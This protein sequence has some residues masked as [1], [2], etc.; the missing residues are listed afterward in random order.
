MVAIDIEAG[1]EVQADVNYI[2]NPRLSLAE[3]K[4]EFCTEDES[5]STMQT[6]PGEVMAIRSARALST[7]L[8]QQGFL[9][10][11]HVTS[12]ADFN[13]IEGDP[14]TDQLY[15]EEMSALLQQVT[16]ASFAIML[17]TGKKRFGESAID[18]L[19]PLIN[20][21]P[22]RYAHADNTDISA[23]EMFEYITSAT[24]QQFP[25]GARWAMYNL[26]RAVSPPPQDFP[27]AVC[28]AT[29]VDPADEV[30][31]TAVTSTLS[32][33]DMRHD[34]TGYLHNPRHRWH[35]YPDMTKDEVIIFKAHDSQENVLRR[36]P[37]TAFTD[38]TCPPGTPTR[39][40]VESRGLAIFA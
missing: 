29:S 35:Y 33:G 14:A 11:D 17:G 4:L 23:S 18:K 16:G 5:L 15:N 24:G 8:D 3:P 28:D 31:V 40:S 10:V 37:H 21:K 7:S 38:P 19:A 39:A 30:P 13:L 36:V 22:A 1:L 12:V 25:K 6:L 9:L 27:L 34:T 32:T 2:R 20:A 26:W